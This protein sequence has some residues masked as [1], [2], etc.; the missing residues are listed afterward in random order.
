MSDSDF[1]RMKEYHL[2]DKSFAYAPRKRVPRNGHRSNFE[3]ETQILINGDSDRKASDAEFSDML[4]EYD[5]DS[6]DSEVLYH[7]LNIHLHQ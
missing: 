3:E 7:T 5:T 4:R 6:D 1:E 2:I